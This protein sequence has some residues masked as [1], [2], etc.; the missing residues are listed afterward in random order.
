MVVVL[1]FL[2]FLTYGSW[3]PLKIFSE[4]IEDLGMVLDID[5]NGKQRFQTKFLN[6]VV[7]E[8]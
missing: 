2:R 7:F 3:A 1:D 6:N 5:Y 4:H 8:F